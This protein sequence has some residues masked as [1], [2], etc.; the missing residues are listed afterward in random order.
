MAVTIKSILELEIFK[1]AKESAGINN[2][3]KEIRNISVIDSPVNIYEWHRDKI[4][5]SGDF[6]I[7]SLHHVKDDINDML[8]LI[9]FLDF[10]G[11]SGLCIIDQYIKS[12]PSQL[13]SYA[14]TRDFSIFL[15][16]WNILYS[17]II[18]GVMELIFQDKSDEINAL[19]ID[20]IMGLSESSSEIPRLM[21]EI[22][23]DFQQYILAVYILSPMTKLSLNILKHRLMDCTYSISSVINYRNGI[24][25]LSSFE[26]KNSILIESLKKDIEQIVRQLSPDIRMVSSNLYP[27]VEYAKR[28]LSEVFLI[29][30]NI[31]CFPEKTVEYSHLGI[32]E[33]LLPLIEIDEFRRFCLKIFYTIEKY[34]T[35]SHGSLLKTLEC[36]IDCNGDY[37][38]TAETMFQHENTI[39]HRIGKIQELLKITQQKNDLY[40]HLFI[41][42]KGLKLMGFFNN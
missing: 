25:I 15:I 2:P 30:H 14:N 42:V 35:D 11:A 32:Y 26:Q 41:A 24:L 40:V 29:V 18:T 33:I 7:T 17:D 8:S 38:K 4:I 16:D 21:R 13:I 12:L 31:N 5:R 34:D 6:F 10:S 23:R 9:Q 3:D 28:T 27:G 20:L 1:N 39:R 36:F 22:N 37:K 19:K